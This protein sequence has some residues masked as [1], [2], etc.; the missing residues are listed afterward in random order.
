MTTKALD[1]CVLGQVQRDTKIAWH[2]GTCLENQQLEN[3]G[4]KDHKFKATLHRD[5]NQNE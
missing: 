5:K 2:S 3:G 4:R 1:P